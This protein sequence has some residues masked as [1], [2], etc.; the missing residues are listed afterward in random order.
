AE[1]RV[2]ELP[3]GYAEF[4]HPALAYLERALF[5]DRPPAPPP[6]DGAVRFLEGAG[7][8][9]VLELVGD[10][11]LQLARAGTV[12]EEIAV[13][14]PAPERWR[15]PLE[16]AFGPLGAPYAIEGRVRLAQTPFGRAL[17]SL[18]RFAWLDG[19]RRELYTFLRSPF[20]GLPRAHVDYLEGR[21]RG[22]AVH[23]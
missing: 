4:G 23:R 7:A 18:L 3:P 8:R 6:L 13:V 15:T 11:I 16:T 9:G 12:L 21:L 5:A 10:E 22:R 14:C 19:G 20:S 1:G 2:E 17:R